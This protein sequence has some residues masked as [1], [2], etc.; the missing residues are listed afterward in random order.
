MWQ[1][2]KNKNIYGTFHFG[3]NPSVGN[4]RI[5]MLV[6]SFLLV[7]AFVATAYVLFK[8]DK[9]EIISLVIP[10]VMASDAPGWWYKQYFGSS[11]CTEDRCKPESDPDNDKLTNAQEFFYNTN[12]LNKDTNSNGFDDGKDVAN[13]YDPSKPGKVTFDEAASDD[14]IFG[15][16]LVFNEDVKKI[17][18]ETIAPNSV[19]YPVVDERELAVVKDNSKE[20]V[21]KYFKDNG[22]VV[23][24]YFPKNAN[25]FIKGIMESNDPDKINDLKYRAAKIRLELK[26]LEVPESLVPLHKL[27]LSFM[28]LL[29]YVLT[30]PSA[31]ALADERNPE[32]NLWFDKVQSFALVNQKMEEEMSRLKNLYK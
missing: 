24:N 25:E 13:N 17:L 16:S 3:A 4:R 30:Q 22:D 1:K 19:T 29:P 15:E 14:A 5:F 31:A 6:G 12:P 7:V 23:N 11:V 26:T 28:D 21:A 27:T 10:E 20:A 32:G 9:K 8:N 18:N 2:N